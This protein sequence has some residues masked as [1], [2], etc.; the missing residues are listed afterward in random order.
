MQPQFP[1]FSIV[2]PAYNYARTLPRAVESVLSQSGNDYELVVVND[3]ST[4]NTAEVLAQLQTRFGDKFTYHNK[5]NGG[6]AA[7]RNCGIDNSCGTYL[8]FLDADDEMVPGALE[9]IRKHISQNS[10][11]QMIIGGHYSCDETGKDSEHKVKPIPET[12]LERLKAYLLEKK[13]S[14]SHGS[15]AVH[16]DVF[17]Q[18]RYPE[19]FRNSEDISMFA[20]ILA[21]FHCTA[22][23]FPV[24][25][26]HKHGD[27]LRHNTQYAESIGTA[28]ISE[29]FDPSRVPEPLQVLRE[30][31]SAQRNLS[32]FRTFFL[33]GNYARALSCYFTAWQHSDELPR[34]WSYRKKAIQASFWLLIGKKRKNVATEAA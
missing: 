25:R 24:A 29:V 10:D 19:H 7:T 30:P 9:A 8:I 21:N 6:P 26:I 27:S 4:D 1:L 16:R 33:A 3:G 5:I 14:V 34:K 18:Y 17:K 28:L 15:M 12:P 23:D 13:L 31:Y 2:I 11:S 32:L 20:Y 22:L